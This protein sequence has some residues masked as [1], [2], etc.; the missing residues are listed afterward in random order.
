MVQEAKTAA[1]TTPLVTK[2]SKR[3]HYLSSRAINGRC[4]TSINQGK[5]KNIQEYAREAKKENHAKN[6]ET[7]IMGRIQEITRQFLGKL[8]TH[9]STVHENPYIQLVKTN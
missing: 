5:S 2:N 1:I 4:Q 9:P 6:Q 8:S 3:L 7:L